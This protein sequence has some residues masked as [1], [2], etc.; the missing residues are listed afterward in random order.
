[1]SSGFH[2]LARGVLLKGDHVLIGK[3]KG[4]V[5]EFLPGGHVEFGESAKDSQVREMQEEMGLAC[6]VGD[7]LGVVEHYWMKG[8]ELQCEV[9]QLYVMECEA[10]MDHTPPPTLEPHLTFFWREAD[11]LEDLEPFPLRKL[12]KQYMNGTG[13]VWWEST[14]FDKQLRTEDY[15]EK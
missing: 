9:N 13:D 10:L 12:V 11:D 3:A 6:T 14:I 1:M 8:D 4:Y 2:H 15:E 7:F 5:N